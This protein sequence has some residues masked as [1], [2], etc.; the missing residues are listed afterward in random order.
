MRR[1]FIIV[2][3][4]I[5]VGCASVPLTSIPKLM[6][7]SIETIDPEALELAVLVPD[8]VGIQPGTARF[9]IKMTDKDT[10]RTLN[11]SQ[12]VDMPVSELDPGLQRK[13]KP[14]QT[15]RRFKLSEDAAADLR[16]YREEAI[17]MR[18]QASD[19]DGSFSASVGFCRIDGTMFPEQVPLVFYVRTKPGQN[20]FKLFK[21]QTMNTEEIAATFNKTE[22]ANCPPTPQPTV[23]DPLRAMEAEKG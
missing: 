15:V 18:E 1:V 3:A 9:S 23:A 17:A 5:L 12:V 16:A 6:S 8:T 11:T 20:F 2:S 4:A 22:K 13:I 10:G 21:T 14:G 7:L 19:T